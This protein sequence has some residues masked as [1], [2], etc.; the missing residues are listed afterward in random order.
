MTVYAESRVSP[1]L[2]PTQD[3][4]RS[5][6]RNA[7]IVSEID[8]TAWWLYRYG[9]PLDGQP[10]AAVQFDEDDGS[11]E[12]AMLDGIPVPTLSDLIALL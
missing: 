10:D 3:R 12:Y 4:V 7:W 2:T 5:A 6:A 1:P 9:T 8:S 11:F